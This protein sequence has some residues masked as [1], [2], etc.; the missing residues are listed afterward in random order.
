MTNKPENET[1]FPYQITIGGGFSLYKGMTLRDY[2]AAAALQG[3]TASKPSCTNKI[4]A[5]VCYSLADDMLAE[6]NKANE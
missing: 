6:R 5:S 2:F 4:I 3:M 1:V